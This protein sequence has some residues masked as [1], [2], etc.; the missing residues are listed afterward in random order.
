MRA[1]VWDIPALSS[2]KY[3][4]PEQLPAG[5][6]LF[7]DPQELISEVW[8]GPREKSWIPSVVKKIVARYSLD[9]PVKVSDKLMNRRLIQ[10]PPKLHT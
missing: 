5:L 1:F 9:I 6:A 7:I 2:Q 3:L 8:V 10:S 4:H